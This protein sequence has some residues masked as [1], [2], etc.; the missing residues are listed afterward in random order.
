[1]RPNIKTINLLIVYAAAILLLGVLSI[2]KQV[3]VLLGIAFLIFI[4]IIIYCMHDM[5]NR[6]ALLMFVLSF[7]IFLLGGE[8]TVQYFGMPFENTFSKE[9]DAHA[10]LC[11][12]LSLVFLLAGFVAADH[13]HFHPGGDPESRR[14]MATLDNEDAKSVI[15]RIG[16]IGSWIAFVPS[17]IRGIES[18]LY[19]MANGYVSYY[20]TYKTHLPGIVTTLGQMYTM[21]FIIFIATCPSRK[22]CTLPI[23]AYVCN[24]AL[25]LLSGRRLTVGSALLVI[26]CYMIIRHFMDPKEGWLTRRRVILGGIFLLLLIGFLY[27]YRFIRYNMSLEG[28]GGPQ[29]F[30]NFFNQQGISID[31]IKFQQL[32]KGDRLG[33]VSLYYT[34]RYLRSSIFTRNFFSFPRELYEMRT[35]QTALYTNNLADYIAFLYNERSYYQGYGLGSCY[36][37]EAFH[38]WG[39]AGV[40]LVNF[41]YGWV[42]NKFFTFEGKRISIWRIAIG[43]MLLERLMVTPRYGAD[44][45]MECF[46]NLTNMI[47]FVS[48]IIYTDLRICHRIPLRVSVSTVTIDDGAFEKQETS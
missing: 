2:I 26:I 39:Y 4:T 42:F 40:A 1:M 6:A 25:M 10:F 28:R 35:A 3:S 7:F 24:G 32:Y 20:T 12:A 5:K 11:L 18:G 34:I 14:L 17:V 29:I 36:I 41:I 47:I 33:C 13:L 45:V 30:L 48:A 21:F 27:M 46:Y 22:E 43:F 19:V 23:M 37:A 9:I 16:L 38:D 44:Y 31:I 15:R 8:M